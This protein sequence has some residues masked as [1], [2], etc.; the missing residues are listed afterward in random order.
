MKL[1]G[2]AGRAPQVGW[3]HRAAGS[4]SRCR[5]K[6]SRIWVGWVGFLGQYRSSSEIWGRLGIVVSWEQKIF[7]IY[8]ISSL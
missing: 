5:F 3:V 7:D 8:D 1:R 2:Q 4:W 6:S